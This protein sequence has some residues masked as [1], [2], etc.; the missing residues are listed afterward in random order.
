MGETIETGNEIDI[1]DK[2]Q[3]DAY[4]VKVL[5]INCARNC[6]SSS[7][8]D[9]YHIYILSNSRIMNTK[10]VL[11]LLVVLM[12]LTV[13]EAYA[14]TAHLPPGV[15]VRAKRELMGVSWYNLCFYTLT[16]QWLSLALCWLFEARNLI[17]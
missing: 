6:H 12:A 16:L 10:S 13:H 4:I 1:E 9:A 14:A 15:V 3:R 8:L 2:Q 11:F 7:N 5:D 17:F